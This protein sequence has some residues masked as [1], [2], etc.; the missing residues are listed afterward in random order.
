MLAHGGSASRTGR[1]MQT[2][3]RG[4]GRVSCC[5]ASKHEAREAVWGEMEDAGVARFPFPP[6]GRIPNFEGS[7]QAAR[8]L[9]EHDLFSSANA[10]KVNPD[11][12]QRHVR[13]FLLEEEVMVL[14]PTPRL[15]GG[16]HVLDPEEIQPED[17]KDAAALSKMDAWAQECPLED[18]PELD[19]IV[20]G[21]VAVTRA[22]HR[23]GKGE[24]YSDLEYAIL[25]E[26]GHP[27]VPV[28]TTVHPVQIVDEVPREETDVPLSLIATPEGLHEVE[29]PPAPPDGIRWGDLDEKRLEEMPLL[30]ELAPSGG[31]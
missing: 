15:K 6:H 20:A 4:R 8:R 24:G 11:A 29:D 5:F 9:V 17:R 12:P 31:T 25:Q 22:G 26:V 3:A 30:R 16:F 1:N 18:L 19:A 2:G 7:E 23:V 28:A 21:S 27:H 13:R 10:V 14:V